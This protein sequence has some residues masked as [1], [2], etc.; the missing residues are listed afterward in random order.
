MDKQPA[1]L[2][3]SDRDKLKL[4]LEENEAAQQAVGDTFLTETNA[5]STPEDQA[6]QSVIDQ[7]WAS[8]DTDR[9]GALDK[10]ETKKLVVDTLNSIGAIGEFS[11]E[12]FEDIFAIFDKDNS[13][14]VEKAEMFYFIK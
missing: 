9:S 1:A 3:S 14:T 7:I 11:E 8:Y 6:I 4:H 2:P 10:A 5:M 13:G 12:L